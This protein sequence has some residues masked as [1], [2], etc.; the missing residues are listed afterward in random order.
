M[1]DNTTT[2][3]TETNVSTSDL[4]TSIWVSA[5]V[6]ALLLLLWAA[7][8]GP[9][10]SIY[11]KRAQLPDLAWRP[12]PLKLL[13]LHRLWSYLGPV[14]TV[15][16]GELLRSA[17]L[18]AL[19][20]TRCL[21]LGLHLFLP[22]AVLGCTVLIPLYA[23]GHGLESA[24]TESGASTYGTMRFTMANLTQRSSKLWV[25]FALNYLG[26]AWCVYVIVTH[27]KS[28]VLLR[29]VALRF[30]VG[31]RPPGNT[32]ATAIV[33]SWADSDS[34][35]ARTRAWQMLKA[36]I[37]PW[38]MYLGDVALAKELV[39][40]AHH[41]AA[42]QGTAGDPGPCEEGFQLLR[43]NE[44]ATS[45]QV[46]EA[47]LPWW[48]HPEDMPPAVSAE[49]GASAVVGGKPGAHLRRR[50]LATTAAGHR[51]WANAEHYAVLYVLSGT[52]PIRGLRTILHR[53]EGT[54]EATLGTGESEQGGGESEPLTGRSRAPSRSNSRELQAVPVGGEPSAPRL[55]EGEAGPGAP[56]PR[57]LEASA[58]AA[59][60]DAALRLVYPESFQ[61]LI[62]V[63][64]HKETDKLLTQWDA[65]RTKLDK[66]VAAD[67]KAASKVPSLAADIEDG[68]TGGADGHVSS[69]TGSRC[70]PRFG[71]RKPQPGQAELEGAVD[72][73]EGEIV[74]ARSRALALPLPTAMFAL[75]SSQADA[76][77]A[78]AGHVGVLAMAH[79]RSEQAP[80]PCD[81]NWPALWSTLQGRFVRG[82]ISVG[83]LV[84]VMLFPIG[85]LVGALTN[86][87]VAVCGDGANDIYWA[88]FC[89]GSDGAKVVKAILTVFL[90]VIISAFWDTY[91]LPI[92]FYCL[93]QVERS[94]VSLS[95]LD[96]RITRLFF[97]FSVSNTFLQA[98]L[99]GAA[100]QQL[101]AMLSSPGDLWQLL[102]TSIPA[103]SNWVLNYTIQHALMINPF[104]FCWPHDGTVLF[105]FFRAAG[106]FRPTCQRDHTMIRTAPSY[107]AGRHYGAFFLTFVF[108]LSYSLI[109]PLVLP[110]AYVYFL[111]AWVT[112][113][114]S[115]LFFYQC[116]YESDGRILETLLEL[117]WWTLWVASIFVSFVFLAKQSYVAAGVLALTN[118]MIVYHVAKQFKARV[119][120]YA[121]SVPLPAAKAAPR[122][123]VD[124]GA[125]LPP[126]L[127][128]GAVG[129]Y[130]E[131]GLP[132]EKYGIVRYCL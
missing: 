80:A 62:H 22:L 30:S 84:L 127:R 39:R 95:S 116:S 122:A 56:G 108:G 67:A 6:G 46:P 79:Y 117:M 25:P 104:R 49:L 27:Y 82:S 100:F 107:R 72:A 76:I 99:G 58:A 111:T 8:R 90:P 28:M 52:P 47:V 131:W 85:L 19:V 121:H 83:C 12:P 37:S 110:A 97:G 123:A 2:E 96:D 86:L 73:L 45:K 87:S 68:S 120:G 106:L 42:I 81:V 9:L 35:A 10:R 91:F 59:E 57:Q 24:S 55:S 78:A 70:R 109:A 11:T 5:A 20:L 113:R 65:A 114:Y 3:F 71:R 128:R 74:E 124:P 126:P 118:T 64:P 130:P 36:L 32:P 115:A 89:E 101:G 7:V 125:Y 53:L 41:A 98:V 48:T 75:F 15:S 4:V 92:T 44:A 33:G 93:A 102:G 13:G 77:T 50:V 40:E 88:W 60:L 38:Q 66:H 63:Y 112:W 94:H 16:D 29:V 26:L 43:A 61:Q 103:A 14:F 31:L 34:R 105:V 23:T 21:V 51:V 18:D 129:W 132:W 119:G 17:G 1:S 69:R 54:E